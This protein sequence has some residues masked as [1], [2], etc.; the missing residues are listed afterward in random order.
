MTI[1]ERAIKELKM[2][3]L[4]DKDS[5]YNGMIGKSVEELLKVFQ[6]QGH[7]GFSAS[8]VASIFKDVVLGGIL[9]PLKGTPEEWE[10][11][12]NFCDGEI[13]FQNK[14]CT[15]V[16]STGLNGENAY[17]VEGIHFID[18]NGI[19]FTCGKS[20]VPVTFPYIPDTKKIIEGSEEAKE[21]KELFE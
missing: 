15:S 4:Y 1:T 12:S 5:D 2:A 8:I 21:Y 11:I 14:R 17:D 20:H 3:G 16:F 9:S 10:D 7:S 6:S 13:L 18:K 19:S